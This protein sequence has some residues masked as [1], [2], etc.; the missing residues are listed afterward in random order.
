MATPVTQDLEARAQAAWNNLTAQLAGMAPY[1]ERADEPGEWTA[2]EVLTHLLFPAGWDAV[3]LMKSF[4]DRDLPVIEIEAGDP[5]MTPERRTMTLEQLVQALDAQRR[6]VLTYLESLT[7]ADLTRKARIPLFKTF[8]GTEE[9]P[10]PVFVG[11]MFE[12]H[13]NDHA[14]QLAKIRDAVGLPAVG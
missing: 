14:S 3:E 8:M 4:A 11:A 2:R 10:L 7:E 6:A 13:W 5:F 12:Y 1:L 9:I